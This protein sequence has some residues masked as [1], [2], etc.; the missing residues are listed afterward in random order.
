MRD[1]SSRRWWAP[2]PVQS[3]DSSSM[4]RSSG[5]LTG[6]ACGLTKAT[7]CNHDR[8]T[9]VESQN[10][11]MWSEDMRGID[12]Q[13]F[14]REVRHAGRGWARRPG[15]LIPALLALGLGIGANTAV[16]SVVNGILLRRLQ[17]AEPERLVALWPEHF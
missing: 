8:V 4:S 6:C 1:F 2:C 3:S 5:L 11:K 16:F 7:S 17:Y 9:V 10:P 15:L 12:F 13:L 14:A